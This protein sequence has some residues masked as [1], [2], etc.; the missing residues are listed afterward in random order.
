MP[1]G[2]GAE[3][4]GKVDTLLYGCVTCRHMKAGYVRVLQVH[5]K[6][7]LR[8]LGRRKQKR[9]DHTLS[10]ANALVK[11]DPC[12][13]IDTTVCRRRMLFAGFVRRM[14]EERLPER[15]VFVRWLEV[16]YRFFL[17]SIA[18]GFILYFSSGYYAVP[19]APVAARTTYVS[20]T[21]V[22]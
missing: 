15:A 18:I 14:G 13:S 9:E 4:R 5:H 11:T 3:I 6:M 16:S 20:D 7:L 8:C 12:E 19:S 10:Y 2:A 17:F 22:R 21:Y 1:E